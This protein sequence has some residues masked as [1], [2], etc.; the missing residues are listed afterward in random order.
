MV[1]EI[2]QMSQNKAKIMPAL[3]QNWLK[4]RCAVMRLS[5]EGNAAGHEMEAEK[6]GML[7][8]CCTLSSKGATMV[9][10]GPPS[11]QIDVI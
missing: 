5:I 6:G 2:N 1:C 9:R 3:N 10:N 7:G 11:P 4:V 8:L